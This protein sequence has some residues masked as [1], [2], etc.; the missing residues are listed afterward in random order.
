M[1]QTKIAMFIPS[2]GVGGLQSVYLALVK[3]LHAQGFAIDCVLM[4]GGGPGTADVPDGVRIIALNH[5]A[6]TSPLPLARYLRQQQPTHLIAFAETCNMAAIV[7]RW[8]ARSPVTL[9]LTVHNTLSIA[10]Q[11]VRTRKERLFPALARRLYPHADRIVAVS[12]GVADDYADFIGLD[13]AHIDVIYNPI[14]I[15]T[16]QQKSLAPV[17]HRWF[18]AHDQPIVLGVGRMEPQ[19]DFP[20]LVRA[21]AEL[22]AQM[23]CR[24]CLVGDGSQR[25]A[26]ERLVAKLGVEDDVLFTGMQ[27]NPFPYMH[28]ADVFVLSSVHE[29]FGAVLVE[30]MACGCRVV[31]TDCPHGPAEILADGQYG[32]LVPMNDPPAMAAAIAAT[33]ADPLPAATVRARAVDFDQDRATATYAALIRSS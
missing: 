33:L 29:G 17:D 9:I 23:A 18:T 24:L 20:T 6:V 8:L 10:V 2:L 13:R 7:A 27:A 25:G 16:I 31:S 3:G 5:R 21:F 1:T 19:K 15:A 32:R 22:R 4:Q 28:G 12:G 11:H 30:A 14:P 26:L